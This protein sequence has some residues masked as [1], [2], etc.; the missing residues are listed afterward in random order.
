MIIR[1]ALPKYCKQLKT[2]I[3]DQNLNCAPLNFSAIS[4]INYFIAA[5]MPFWQF[6]R[7][8]WWL[9]GQ[10]KVVNT[11][12]TIKRNARSTTNKQYGCDWK[13]PAEVCKSKFKMSHLWK[14]CVRTNKLLYF[15]LYFSYLNRSRIFHKVICNVITYHLTYQF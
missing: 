1:N 11:L 12:Y 6:Y 10:C 5:F 14:M 4:Q 9:C 13:I 8:R 3:N 7:I 2:K 15:S